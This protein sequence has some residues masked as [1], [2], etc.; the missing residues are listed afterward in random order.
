M[1]W[2]KSHMHT[3]NSEKKQSQIRKD[4]TQIYVVQYQFYYT[5]RKKEYDGAAVKN[6]NIY[7]RIYINKLP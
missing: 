7:A 6:N 3:N 5:E 2:N 4:D 1:L